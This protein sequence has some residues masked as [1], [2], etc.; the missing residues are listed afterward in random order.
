LPTGVTTGPVRAI[1]TDTAT[2]RFG[3]MTAATVAAATVNFEMNI[4]KGG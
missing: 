3:N 1:N 2:M 4:Q